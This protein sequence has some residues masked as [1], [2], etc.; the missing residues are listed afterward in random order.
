DPIVS[1]F[2]TFLGGLGLGFL[3]VAAT[4]PTTF[5]PCVVTCAVSLIV[6]VHRWVG[7]PWQ[8]SVS[9][10]VVGV[11]LTDVTAAPS[12]GEMVTAALVAGTVAATSGYVA[13]S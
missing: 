5:E 9:A 10:T 2:V 4:M 3:L 12:A 6:P 7:R 1:S 11:V 8:W 13:I